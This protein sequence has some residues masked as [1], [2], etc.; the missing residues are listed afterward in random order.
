ML[1]AW[2]PST[3]PTET[4]VWGGVNGQSAGAVSRALGQALQLRDQ[5]A[6]R[7]HRVGAQL[8]LAGVG[9]LAGHG[10]VEGVDA[11]VRDHELHLRGLA[12]D[13]P[14]RR[15]NRAVGER[16]HHVDAAQA[17]DL[18]VV[19]DREVDRARE[20]GRREL[21]HQRERAGEEALHVAAAAAVEAAAALGQGER[22]AGPG[23]VGGR[24]DVGVGGQHHP[25]RDV[26][27]DGG[28]QAG[29]VAVRVGHPRRGHA[30]GGEVGLDER[31]QLQVGGVRDG[32][33]RDQPG[34]HLARRVTRGVGA[35]GFR[36]T[37]VGGVVSRDLGHHQGTKGTKEEVASRRWTTETQRHRDSAAPGWPGFPARGEKSRYRSWIA[38]FAR[39]KAFSVSL[40]FVYAFLNALGV[41][42]SWW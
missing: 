34:Q 4:V 37:T 33:E 10:R 19:G 28:V 3:V 42:V 5:L 36:G 15:R 1:S 26:G 17:P 31:D 7:H 16:A 38:R 41:F 40:W 29:L 9:F 6:R 24:H 23:L 39:K 12:H 35:H 2:P 25:A 8:G 13:H 22:V 18:L 21:R 11:L 27:A 30:V 20:A 32:V 14:A